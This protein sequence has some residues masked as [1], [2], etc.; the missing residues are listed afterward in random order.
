MIGELTRSFIIEKTQ[1]VKN[2][3]GR[4]SKEKKLY[5]YITSS[6]RFRKMREKIEMKDKLDDSLRKEKK[7]IIEKWDKREY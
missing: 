7:Y 4:D 3:N 5:D 6:A 1:V 2:G